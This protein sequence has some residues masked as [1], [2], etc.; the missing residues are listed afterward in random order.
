MLHCLR[1]ISIWLSPACVICHLR[2]TFDG[3]KMNCKWSQQNDLHFVTPNDAARKLIMGTCPGLANGL[4]DGNIRS[5]KLNVKKSASKKTWRFKWIW[6]FLWSE[7]MLWDWH[8]VW[9]FDKTLGCIRIWFVDVFARPTDRFNFQKSSRYHNAQMSNSRWLDWHGVK[10]FDI[11][12]LK[13]RTCPSLSNN[14]TTAFKT[15][16]SKS[17]VQQNLN[18]THAFLN[19]LF[20]DRHWSCA[21]DVAHL[22]RTLSLYRVAKQIKAMTVK[23][24]SHISSKIS[25]KSLEVLVRA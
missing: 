18:E 15:G 5:L 7:S 9:K 13:I 23:S 12:R 10:F 22:G 25:V 2:P 17:N 11:C 3:H 24:Y 14:W 20:N 4:E 6:H 8:L 1:W 16:V 19:T 21:E